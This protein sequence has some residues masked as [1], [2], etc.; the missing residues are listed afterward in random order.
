MLKALYILIFYLLSSLAFA[1]KDT[2]NVRW[3]NMN[4]FVGID[5]GYS[6]YDK[7]AGYNGEFNFN[8]VFNP[9]YFMIKTFYGFAPST[10]FGN[11]KKAVF[12]MGFSTKS[13]KL[14]SWH[15]L[16]GIISVVP[17]KEYSLKINNYE[18]IHNLMSGFW[19]LETGFYVKP[20]KLKRILFG[21]NASMYSVTIWN[22]AGLQGPYINRWILNTNFSVNY[23]LN[24]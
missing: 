9:Q 18:D 7:V 17:E 5:V 15:M 2:S 6:G 13:N 14:I 16:T 10:N 21:L 3:P 23:K 24:R 19:Y 20:K 4:H 12:S 1:Q 8:Y 11:L 22:N